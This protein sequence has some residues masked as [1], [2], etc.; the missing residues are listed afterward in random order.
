[1]N[2]YISYHSLL[3]SLHLCGNEVTVRCLKTKELINTQFVIKDYNFYSCESRKL[4]TILDY[5]YG[6]FAWY[7]SGSR[8]V[9]DISKYSKFWLKLKNEDNTVN[10]N[11]GWLIFYKGKQSGFDWSYNQLI[12][13]INS[14]K[15]IILYND[16]DCYYDNNKDFICTQ[17]QHF[18]IRNMTLYSIIYLRSSDC[19]LGLTYDIP[20]YS[21]V[22]Q[23]MY[24]KLLENYKNIKLG[25]IYVNIGSIHVYE[26]KFNL[27]EK[28]VNSI[29]NYYFIKLLSEIPLHKSIKWYEDNLEKYLKIN[30]WKRV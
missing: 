15:A 24:L 6:E 12:K 11:Y 18:F 25:G 23:Q 1:M 10:S 9:N 3:K 20:W 7:F 21:I 17:L 22:H 28:I 27:L 13:D 4:E 16:R 26:N 29:N 2:N 8:N 14:R 30:L 19:I 5:L